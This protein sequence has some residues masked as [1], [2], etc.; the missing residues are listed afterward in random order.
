MQPQRL[1]LSKLIAYGFGIFGW[2]LSL[3]IVST[4][5]SYMYLPPADEKTTLTNLVPQTTY[6]YVF[7]IIALVLASGRLFDALIDPLIANWS[8]RL[9]HRLGRRI[10]FM[11]IAPLFVA[12]FCSLM[13]LPPVKGESIDNVKWLAFV[14]IGYYFFFGLYVIPYNALLS[15]LGHYPNGKMQ[16]STSQSV[17]FMAGVFAASSVTKAAT[18]FPAEWGDL[19]QLEY[20]VFAYNLFGAT[21]MLL[22]AFVIDETKY[23]RPA[24][25]SEPVFQSLRTALSIKNFRVFAFADGVFF[26]SVALISS[27]L[28]YYITAMLGM[29]KEDGFLYM[30]VMLITTLLMYY[31]VN[32]LEKKISKKKL[33]IFAFSALS[34]VFAGIY[35]LGKVPI[36]PVMQVV[37]LMVLFGTFDSFL[38]ILPNT[39]VADIAQAEAQRSGQNKEGM[40]FGMRA[41]FQKLGQTLGVMLF[42]MLTLYGKDPCN[43]FGLRLSGVLGSVLCVLAAVVYI[44][45]NEKDDIV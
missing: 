38:G 1:P 3:N 34:V 43:D 33:I 35:F 29:S 24:N 22:P 45:Y 25:A 9:N 37:L 8:D 11:R 14:Q 2:S 21:C 7:N 5:L 23:C 12:L 27:G 10:P 32:V 30:G 41:L 28:L 20:A 36:H 42:M 16:L 19:K 18:F 44:G 39:V 17:G 31:P 6:L 13:F 26:M 15:E 4:L 40:F